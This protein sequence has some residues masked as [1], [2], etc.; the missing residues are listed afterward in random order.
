MSFEGPTRAASTSVR[1]LRS[2]TCIAAATILLPALA[3]PAHPQELG[4]G[5]MPTGVYMQFIDDAYVIG[6]STAREILDQMDA[7]GPGSGWTRFPYVYSWTYANERVP[8][9]NG[10]P[11]DHCRPIDFELTFELTATYPRWTPPA[12]TSDELAE[13]WSNFNDQLERQWQ[14]TREGMIARARAAATR[15]RRFEEICA[16]INQRLRAAVVDAFNEP[17]PPTDDEPRVR[18]RWPP[19]GYDHLLRPS[20]GPTPTDEPVRPTRPVPAVE[21]AV[22]PAYDIDAAVRIDLERGRATG[23]VMELHHEGELNFREAFGVARPGDEAP[24]EPDASFDFPSFTEVLIATVASSLAAEGRLAPEAPVG[25]Y[26]TGL[27]PR[28]G[29]ATTEQLLSHRAGLDNAMVPDTADWS[30]VLDQLDDRAL[31]TAPGAVPS[32]SRYSY[33]LVARVIESITDTSLEATVG[34]LLLEPLR[35][36]RTSFGPRSASDARDG[37]PATHTTAG[38]V[39]RFWTAWLDGDIEGVGPLLLDENALDTSAPDGRTFVGGH[40]Q[41]RIGDMPRISLMCG[42]SATGYS[43][44]FQVYPN[45]RTILVFWGR[46]DLGGPDAAGAPPSPDRWPKESVRLALSRMAEALGLDDAVY[47]PTMLTGG[48][49][50]GRSPRRCAEPAVSER[51]VQDFGPRAPAGDWVGR[52]VNGEWFF[53]LQERDGYLASPVDPTRAPYSVRHY[54]GDVY[55]ADMDIPGGPAIGFPLRLITDGAGRRYVVLGQRAYVH[56]DDRPAR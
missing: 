42:A 14:Q 49:Q 43:A 52:Y 46:Y 39:A 17:S 5:V 54:G 8:L 20:S 15:A 18:L 19:E 45:T 51:R 34:A 40:W 38:E 30:R 35:L 31:F 47:R 22:T 2:S 41:D 26:L 16:L 50:P 4:P 48:G 36:R 21:P 32:Y 3:R 24:L 55:F 28:L 7:L 10:Q 33:P 12:D 29:S 44:G 1:F 6:G 23:L 9:S 25:D 27:A 37:L 53:E 56:Q 11:S 13:A